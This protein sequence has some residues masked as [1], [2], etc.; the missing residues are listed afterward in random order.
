MN[1]EENKLKQAWLNYYDNN[2]FLEKDRIPRRPDIVYK[3]E[4]ISWADWLGVK[5]GKERKE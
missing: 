2:E 4:W 5:E 1:N 3:D